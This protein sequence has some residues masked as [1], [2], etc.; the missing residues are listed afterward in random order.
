MTENFDNGHVRSEVGSLDE[1]NIAVPPGF[2]E[3]ILTGKLVKMWPWAR[4][5]YKRDMLYDL[6]QIMEAEGMTDTI[7]Y[8]A[9]IKADV[10]VS[11]HMDLIEFVNYFGTS[12][13][14]LLIP[15]HIESGEIIGFSWYENTLLGEYGQGNMFYRKKFWGDAALEASQLALRYG[16]EVFRFKK[17][18]GHSPWLA[19][20]KHRAKL[21]FKEQ[22]AI[23]E[24]VIDRQGKSR[25]LYVGVCTREDFYN[26]MAR[27]DSSASVGSVVG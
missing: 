4:G 21:G 20:V 3:N 22:A 23:P 8:S 12:G 16:F 11:T 26:G 10:P 25:T 7:F 19:S 27:S 1:S 14:L 5:F 9:T 18:W 2:D 13:R 6:W 24:A 17:V 15:Q